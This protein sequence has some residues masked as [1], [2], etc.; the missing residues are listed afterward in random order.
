MS[1]IS[2]TFERARAEKR[3]LAPSTRGACPRFSQP[4][5]LSFLERQNSRPPC[6]TNP[7]TGTSST[8]SQSPD[9]CVLF[10]TASEC[11]GLAQMA[12]SLLETVQINSCPRSQRTRQFCCDKALGDCAI[13]G[14]LVATLEPATTLA[15]KPRGLPCGGPGE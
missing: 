9:L 3:G 5:G 8:R 15:A 10:A 11:C 1:I 2:R 14:R 4:A 13:L 6:G 12:G 7:G